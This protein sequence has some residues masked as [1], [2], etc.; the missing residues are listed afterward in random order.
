MV[1][2]QISASILYWSRGQLTRDSGRHAWYGRLGH[3]IAKLPA[4]V[5]T[6][7]SLDKAKL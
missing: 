4:Q 1:S 7:M 3:L 2:L 5:V 6:G